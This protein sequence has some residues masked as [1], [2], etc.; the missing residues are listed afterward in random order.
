[1]HLTEFE[2][3][4]GQD[5]QFVFLCVCLCVCHAGDAVPEI[6]SESSC[7]YFYF[8]FLSEMD[9]AE[10]RRMLLSARLISWPC[11]HTHTEG[12]DPAHWGKSLLWFE[13]EGLWA[14]ALYQAHC[15]AIS[16]P[17]LL[18]P[19][20]LSHRACA[21]QILGCVTMACCAQ[22]HQCCL[23]VVLNLDLDNADIDRR[24]R[25]ATQFIPLGEKKRIILRHSCLVCSYDFNRV[26]FTD[27]IKL[28]YSIKVP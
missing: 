19:V 22:R 21:L 2:P 5:L 20:S 23:D 9:K 27:N 8:C 25:N 24:G 10:G 15:V 17:L 11:M 13:P 26:T 18:A 14:L 3:Q 7:P 16:L 28:R 12:L 4:W 1:M 6:C